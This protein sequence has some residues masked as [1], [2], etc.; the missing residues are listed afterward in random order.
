MNE[1]V[2]SFPWVKDGPVVL[3]MSALIFICPDLNYYLLVSYITVII[4]FLC[5]T[6][7]LFYFTEWQG[8]DLKM[9]SKNQVYI[10][11]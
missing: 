4:L 10:L 1:N 3:G 2:F 9:R 11:P 7:F 6:N 5:S 8:Q